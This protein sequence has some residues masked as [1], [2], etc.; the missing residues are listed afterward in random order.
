[1]HHRIALFDSTCRITQIISQTDIVRALHANKDKI[2]DCL[3]LRLLDIPGAPLFPGLLRLLVAAHQ[4]QPLWRCTSCLV[5]YASGSPGIR[6][7]VLPRYP[8]CLLD[9]RQSYCMKP[10]PNTPCLLHFLK[11]Q[12]CR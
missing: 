1:M 6:G 2:Q 9:S 4:Q 3:K 8:S 12:I 7:T 11:L 5:W 10:P